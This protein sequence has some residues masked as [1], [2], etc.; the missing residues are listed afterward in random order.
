MKTITLLVPFLVLGF[1]RLTAPQHQGESDGID[2]RSYRLGGIGAFSE[3]VGGGVKKLALSS[4]MTSQEMDALMD[5]A[6]KIAARNRVKLHRETDFLVTDLFPA[7]V[8]E[9][10]H[11]LLIYQDPVKEEYMA[12]KAET[13]KL[14]ADGKYEGEAR[15]NIAREMGRLLSYSEERIEAMLVAAGT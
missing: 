11:V 9:G 12:L 8:T 10:K 15:L 13:E 4:P 5:E 2:K 6:T 3:V 7:S 14:I 1:V